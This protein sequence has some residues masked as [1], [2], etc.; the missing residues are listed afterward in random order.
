MDFIGIGAQ[1]SGTSWL[2]ACLYEHPEI[3]APIKELHFFSRDR[4]QK[5]LKWYEQHFATCSQQ[6]KRGEFSTSYLYSNEAAKRIHGAY[7]E[8]KIIV[9]LRN[10]IDRAFSQYRNAIKAGEI[11]PTVN[12]ES[13]IKTEPSAFKQGYYTGQLRRYFEYF[14]P[15]QIHIIIYEDIKKDPRR[16]IKEIYRFLNIDE[17]FVPEMLERKVN[18]ART[19][20][21]VWID[22]VM[23]RLAEGLRKLGLDRVVWII[24]KSPLPDFIRSLN[25][26]RNKVELSDQTREKLKKIYRD[27][28]VQLSELL[29]R[30]LSK[31]WG[32]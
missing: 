20:R 28:V 14:D 12:F 6:K 25:T 17:S 19:P 22:K 26:R 31:E 29:K 15:K 11:E 21:F 16:V 2:Y 1:K 30:D 9:S 3:C 23:T 5:G 24:K 32:I 13:Y 18:V 8:A 7:P 4:Y 27:E 10:P